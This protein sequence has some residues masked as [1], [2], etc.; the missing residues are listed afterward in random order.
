MITVLMHKDGC[1][2]YS[3]AKISGHSGYSVRG[4]D[5]ICAAVSTIS[6]GILCGIEEVLKCDVTVDEDKDGELDFTVYP[7]MCKVHDC[8]LMM[9]TL[10]WSLKDIAEQYPQYVSYAEVEGAEVEGD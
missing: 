3:R 5:I 7:Q 8:Q 6:Q 2:L 10:V 9:S 1:G 4:S